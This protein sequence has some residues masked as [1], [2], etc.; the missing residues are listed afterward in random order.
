VVI[1]KGPKTGQVAVVKGDFVLMTASGLAWKR[2]MLRQWSGTAW[3]E[4]D[5]TNHVAEY[6]QAGMDIMELEGLQGDVNSFPSVFTRLLFAMFI[7]VGSAI[8]GGGRYKLDGSNNDASQKGFWLGAD[9]T[10][11][12]DKAVLENAVVSGTVYA[13]DGAF[14]GVV[15]ANDGVFEGT[16][17]SGGRYNPDGSENTGAQSGI[18]VPKT[19]SGS[20]LVRLRGVVMNGIVSIGGSR[21]DNQQLSIGSDEIYLQSALNSQLWFFGTYTKAQLFWLFEHHVR[22]C[23]VGANF[24]MSAR[25]AIDNVTVSHINA[26]LNETWTVVNSITF[27]GISSAGVPTSIVLTESGQGSHAVSLML[28]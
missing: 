21:D 23:F 1:A 9:G 19:G 3:A 28:I 11:K 14:S 17:V 10:L 24:R 18:Y 6:M 13:T 26:S 2:G 25:G 22:R 8:Y 20:Q 27:Y 16:L 4:L 5:I 12:A 7:K 15:N